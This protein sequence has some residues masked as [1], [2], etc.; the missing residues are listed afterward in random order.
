M[1]DDPWIY[2]MTIYKWKVNRDT[3][4]VVDQGAFTKTLNKTQNHGSGGGK[5]KKTKKIS[6]VEEGDEEL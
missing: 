4:R 6:V 2:K 3:G 1:S 5:K